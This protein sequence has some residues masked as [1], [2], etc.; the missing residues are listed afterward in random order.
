M[1]ED[2][3]DADIQIGVGKDAVLLSS[4]ALILC[5]AS[6]SNDNAIMAI[7][8]E[9]GHELYPQWEKEPGDTSRSEM[10]IFER[11]VKAFLEAFAV[12]LSPL[13]PQPE[14]PDE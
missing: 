2:E 10:G 14:V 5:R 6:M 13:L 1:V 8:H 9:V 12:D 7:L 4:Q 11:D 3:C